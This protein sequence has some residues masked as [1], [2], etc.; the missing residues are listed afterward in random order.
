MKVTTFS[1]DRCGRQAT[2]WIRVMEHDY[3]GQLRCEAHDMHELDLCPS[4]VDELKKWMAVKPDDNE[5]V[6]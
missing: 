2:A 5:R 3:M 6:E 4:C 1:C